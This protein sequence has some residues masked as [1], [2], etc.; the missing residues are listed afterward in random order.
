MAKRINEIIARQL[1]RARV[2]AG[3]S[4]RD[5]AKATNGV[6]SHTAISKYEKGLSTPGSAA[7]AALSEALDQPLD[8]FIRELTPSLVRVRHRKRSSKLSPKAS[9]ALVEQ[10]GIFF[11]RYQEVENILGV[12]HTYE[13]PFPDEEVTS[14]ESIPNLA[15]RLR[16]KW[17]LGRDPLPN[18]HQLMELKGIKVHELATD[19]D[20]FDGFS[21]WS[22]DGQPLVAIA[23]RL[24]EDIPRK[25]MT[26][27]HELAH[28]ILNIP[29]DMPEKEEE[30]LVWDFAGELLMPREEFIDLFGKRTRIS[31][32]E[33]IDLKG[34]FGV[35]IM[36]MIYRAAK[37][38]LIS[39]H[40]KVSFYKFANKQGWRT[41]GEPGKKAYRGSENS[42]RFEALV[43]RAVV[44]QKI[45]ESKGAALLQVPLGT[46]RKDLEGV[47]FS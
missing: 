25:R 47:T 27:V 29:D 38:R 1:S 14:V 17:E 10:A 46:L 18:V 39:D 7:L 20:A 5:L 22:A 33:L 3:L 15:I 24:N 32:P 36:A 28:V 26:E 13:A 12:S 40:L 37:L 41:K 43:H 42:T 11:E 44:E 16:K 8:F 21:A 45:T 23:Q 31:L 2:V 6:L 35:S 9:H 30:K 34:H 4:L 19:N